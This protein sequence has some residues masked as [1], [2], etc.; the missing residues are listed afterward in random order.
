MEIKNSNPIQGGWFNFEKGNLS[1]NGIE[2]ENPSASIQATLIPSSKGIFKLFNFFSTKRKYP[3]G[4][5]LLF[6]AK[7]GT[8]IPVS[9]TYSNQ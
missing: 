8:R 1:I 5:Y 4:E 7:A 2:E 6:K 9:N 3:K